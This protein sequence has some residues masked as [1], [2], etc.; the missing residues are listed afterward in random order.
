M[1]SPGNFGLMLYSGAAIAGGQALLSVLSRSFDKDVD[2]FSMLRLSVLSW[3]FWG[4]IFLYGSGLISMFILLRYLPLA[5]A[6]VGI[7]AVTVICT[8][9]L[10][11]A[12]GQSIGLLQYFGISMVFLG[13]ILLQR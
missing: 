11:L 2:A 5:Q 9:L 8:V 6:S 3:S 13:M 7:W 12:L 10:T 4:S 1:I